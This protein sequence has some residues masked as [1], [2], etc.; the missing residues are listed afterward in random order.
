MVRKEVGHEDA[1]V[2][3]YCYSISCLIGM[4]YGLQGVMWDHISIS[5]NHIW[6]TEPLILT[7]KRKAPVIGQ[8]SQ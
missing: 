3:W 2:W 4:C 8:G 1:V 6:L 5:A 7:I